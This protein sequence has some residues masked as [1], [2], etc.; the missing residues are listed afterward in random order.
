MKKLSQILREMDSGKLSGVYDVDSFMRREQDQIDPATKRKFEYYAETTDQIQLRQ[1]IFSTR[2]RF[3][4]RALAHNP[5]LTPKEEEQLRQLG[6]EEIN[7]ALDSREAVPSIDAIKEA[8]IDYG[9]QAF[10][11]QTSIVADYLSQ[12][13]PEHELV[14]LLVKKHKMDPEKANKIVRQAKM[15][16]NTGW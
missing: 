10:D 13:V 3:L 1:K 8:N 6:D 15:M 7:A 11:Q 5:N 2:I 12:N 9:R 14:N 16:L 4:Q